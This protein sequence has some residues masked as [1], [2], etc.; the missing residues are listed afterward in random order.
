MKCFLSTKKQAILNA[1]EI[2]S[3][4]NEISAGTR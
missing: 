3:T 2:G 4:S 1:A